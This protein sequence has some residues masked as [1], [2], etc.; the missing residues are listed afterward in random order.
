MPERSCPSG[1]LK[2][3]DYSSGK[4]KKRP[5]L[6]WVLI[7]VGV[8]ARLV[9]AVVSIGSNDAAAWHRFGEEINQYGLLRTYQ[10]P[11]FNHPPIPAYWAAAAIKIVGPGDNLGDVWIFSV[12][13]K[14]PA[15]L[16]DCAAVYL[17]WRI[18]RQRIGRPGALVVAALFA[19]SLDAILVSGYHCNTDSVF[20]ML[21]LLAVYL[22]EDRGRALWSG[23]A[24][25]AAINVKIIPVLLLP[26]M[27]LSFRR[28]RDLAGF[29]A[30]LAPWV[31]P[32]LPPL[33]WAHKHFAENALS[34][35]SVLDRWGINF[36]VLFGRS[37]FNPRAPGGHF[38]IWYYNYARYLI[39]ATVGLWAVVA[40]LLGRWGR[41][42]LAAVTFAIFLVLTPGFGVQYTVLVG[43]LLFAVRVDLAAAYALV[44]GLFLAAVYAAFGIGGVPLYSEWRSLIPPGP[45]FLGVMTWLL[46]V[47]FIVVAWV[48]PV[49]PEMAN[50]PT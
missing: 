41:Y 7:G 14:L 20:V 10:D 4:S 22:M 8:I 47:Y 12:V 35:N 43:L 40:R 49:R 44:A 42:E 33:L 28:W 27:L 17:L 39:M 2:K 50:I 30:G 19:C 1:A 21:C 16:A 25:G 11:D 37:A 15:I 34:Y 18:W 9:L 6:W 31:L 45:A 29:V 48:R 26:P 24:L 46:L 5:Q 3:L 23:L 32:F 38:A 36:F 13:F